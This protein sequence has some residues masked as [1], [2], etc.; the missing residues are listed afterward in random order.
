MIVKDSMPFQSQQEPYQESIGSCHMHYTT[1]LFT[2][3]SYIHPLSFQRRDLGVKRIAS[4]SI[5]LY[6]SHL[7]GF[8]IF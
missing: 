8:H 1:P 5:S 2:L 6:L 7:H 4:L 3:R